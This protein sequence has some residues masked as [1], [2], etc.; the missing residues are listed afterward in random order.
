LAWNIATG[1]LIAFVVIGIILAIL[2]NS[3]VMVIIGIITNVIPL[4]IL[5]GIMG[6]FDINLK[7]STAILFSIA[8]G[9]AVDDTIHFLSKFRQ[10]I[11]KEKSILY[12]L[13]RTYLTTGKAM[14]I[15]SI[16]LCTGFGVLGISSF[17]GTKIIGSLTALTLFFAMIFNLTILPILILLFY[18]RNKIKTEVIPEKKIDTFV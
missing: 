3:V 4:I 11:H 6:Y 18:K 17:V 10:E 14:I 8:F 5:G 16:L 9:I 13:K 2:F 15:T 7:L 1:I 12:A